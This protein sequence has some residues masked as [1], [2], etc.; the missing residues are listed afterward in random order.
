MK[1]LLS[2][3]ALAAACPALA[4]GT[5][6]AVLGY[7]DSFSAYVVT[8]VGWTFQ[9]ARDLTVTEL[10]CFAKVFDDNPAVAFVQVGL[11]DQG[12]S[13]LAYSSVSRGSTLFDQTRY[14]SITP[15]SLDPDQTYH[16]GVYY[17][18]DGLGLDIAGAVAGG[19]VSTS[20][21]VQLLAAAQSDAGFAFPPEV[22]GTLGSLYAGPNFRFQ[23]QPRLNIQLWPTNQVRLSWSTAFPGYTL[24]GNPGLFGTWSNVAFPPAA[25]VF[26][27]G[28][29]FVVYDPIG[30]VSKYYR[31][32]Q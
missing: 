12:G 20:A 28:N 2:L 13:L 10:G 19:S 26:T 1:F 5:S 17:P 9:P 3:A 15:V 25:G 16:L 4:Q 14:E 30:P 29:E 32:L 21:D 7:T 11:W 23:P 6:E 18:G 31:L 22:A 27:I 24:Q 8:T